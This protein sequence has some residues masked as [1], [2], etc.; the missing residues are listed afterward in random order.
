MV[1]SLIKELI[2]S[3]RRTIALQVTSDASLIVRAPKRAPIEMIQKFVHEKLAWI[4][5]KQRIARQNYKP[6]VKKE[7]V[8]GEKF[9]YL[10][11]WYKLSI[12]KEANKPLIFDGKEFLLWDKYLAE[13]HGRFVLWYRQQALAIISQR[14]KLYAD[15]M[16]LKY[17]R[18]RITNA[19]KR[20]GSCNAKKALN[21]S[22]RLI[23]APV[24]II[25]YVAIH[26]LVHLKER[27]HSKRY[28]QNVQL[29]FPEYKKAKSWLNTNNNLMTI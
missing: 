1:Q 25:D 26:E 20:W 4:L 5:E 13:A 11:Q 23:M 19:K 8:N 18:L 12:V 9:L 7:F 2:R 14:V 29:L 6:A 3:N 21:F 15:S 22:W 27:N 28:W 10:G 24:E 16:G 17:S